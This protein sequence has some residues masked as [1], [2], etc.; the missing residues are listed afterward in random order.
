MKVGFIGL[1]NMGAAIA[2][3]L[4]A[5]G[6]ELTVWNRSPGPVE[7][8]VAEGA[9]A[10]GDP[11]E[12]FQAEVVVSM[13]SE[14]DVV[15]RTIVASGALD[16]ARAGAVHV[17][18]ATISVALAKRMEA[19][20]AERGLGYVAAPV[21]GRPNVAAA[22]ELN[23]ICAGEAEAVAKVAPLLQ[24]V[25]KQVWPLGADAY[26]ANVVKIS[27]N[28]ALAS[29]I[30]TLG[31]AAALAHAH[32]VAPAALYEVM[33]GTV[34]NS[35]A[36]RNYAGL[37]AD[38]RFIP[39]GFKMPLGLKDVKLALAAAES[40][41]APLPLGSLLRDHFLEAIAQGDGEKDWSA[42]AASAFRRGGRAIP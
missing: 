38:Q 2:R 23:V 41:G 28:F 4:M 11:G 19:L 30:E 6:C 22:G 34:F 10:A 16:R 29:M 18:M 5:G 13:L 3:R 39:A 20:H 12:S 25:S 17:N 7:A 40:G 36:Y 32:G 21:L 24:M 15:E 9:A 42:L 33:T 27:C 37:I 8:L 35:P 31:E 1:G 26:R 14:D